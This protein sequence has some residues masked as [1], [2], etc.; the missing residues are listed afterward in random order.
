MVRRRGVTNEDLLAQSV[1]S[2]NGRTAVAKTGRVPFLVVARTA[3]DEERR[4]GRREL[5]NDPRSELHQDKAAKKPEA[6]WNREAGAATPPCF[7]G[8]AR[9][10][11]R[12][13]PTVTTASGRMKYT[14]P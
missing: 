3:D 5:G 2:E 7:P 9:P 4:E 10:Q 11:I 12:Y 13:R 1:D 8:D 14:Y 6:A